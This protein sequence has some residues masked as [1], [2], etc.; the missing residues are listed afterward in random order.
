MR[1]A[2]A[3]LDEAA[4]RPKDATPVKKDFSRHLKVSK[5][6]AEDQ[7]APDAAPPQQPQP[8]TLGQLV[9]TLLGASNAE[10][11]PDAATALAAA[12]P[13]A[14]ATPAV[15]LAPELAAIASVTRPD[16]AKPELPL[17]PLEQAVH[18]LLAELGG[19]G[20]DHDTPTGAATTLAPLAPLV[21]ALEAPDAPV[22]AQPVTAIA[23]PAPQPA[24]LASQHH[25]HI[26]LDEPGLRVVM[27]VAVRGSEVNVNVRSS[28]DQTTA[29]LARNA[30][31]LDEAMRAHKLDLNSFSAD[32]EPAHERDQ[33]HRERNPDKPTEPFVLEETV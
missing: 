29:A 14:I 23:A 6:A 22:A 17:T 7:A 20:D 27:T 8:P 4:E 12:K 18:D 25:A 15:E 16:V 32:R 30:G 19:S 21:A 11:H 2:A 31:S 3:K 26:V 13:T 24:E 10:P 9:I 5:K 1:I 33:P 28:D